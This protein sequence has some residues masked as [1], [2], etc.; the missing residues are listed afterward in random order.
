[1]SG[2]NPFQVLGNWIDQAANAVSDA[3]STVASGVN[4]VFSP[5]ETTIS[6]LGSEFG[7]GISAVMSEVGSIASDVEN[8]GATFGNAIGAA[9]S[10]LANEAAS[11]LTAIG[12]ATADAIVSVGSTI[13]QSMSAW[14][15]TDLGGALSVVE[16]NVATFAKD[17]GHALID[18]AADAV[19]P[20][21]S[22]LIDV[23]WDIAENGQLPSLSGLAGDAADAALGE[24]LP[25]VDEAISSAMPGLLGDVVGGE[26]NTAL[27]SFA[28]DLMQHKSS[29]EILSD[30]K[31]DLKNGANVDLKNLVTIGAEQSIQSL[32]DGSGAID[33][34]DIKTAMSI[35][36]DP[37]GTV[38]DLHITAA[39]LAD[40]T[41]A[42]LLGLGSSELGLPD[43]TQI[44]TAG[45]AL[46][47][48]IA[49]GLAIQSAGIVFTGGVAAEIEDTAASIE[50]LSASALNSLHAIEAGTIKAVDGGLVLNMTQALAVVADKLQLAATPPTVTRTGGVTLRCDQA[51]FDTF[52]S[53]AQLLSLRQAGF[54]FVSVSDAVY[55]QWSLPQALAFAQSGLAL[56]PGNT[57]I[58]NASAV[59]LT[60][61]GDGAATL[62]T[63]D[64]TLMTA[65]GVS[66]LHVTG[67]AAAMLGIPAAAFAALAQAGLSDISY[68]IS[69]TANGL[70]A[71]SATQQQ[72]I[73]LTFSPVSWNVA[74]R[75]AHILALTP[76]AQATL[77]SLGVSGIVCVDTAADIEALTAPQIVTLAANGMTQLRVS[78][79]SSAIS[80]TQE[81]ALQTA[82]LRIITGGILTLRDTAVRLQ[83]LTSLNI[84]AM[85]VLGIRH[86]TATTGPVSLCAAQVLALAVAG[87]SVAVPAGTTL[88]VTDSAANLLALDN[89]QILSLATMGVRTITVDDNPVAFTLGQFFAFSAAGIALS[90]PHGAITAAATSF[91]LAALTVDQV[92]K[93]WHRGIKQ[94]SVAGGAVTLFA[95]M[96]ITLEKAQ[97]T[98]TGAALPSC[99]VQDG[100]L[101]NNLLTLSAAQI[102]GLP[103]IGIT[104]L[105]LAA[106]SILTVAQANAI[107]AAGLT[108]KVS[109]GGGPA[110]GHYTFAIAD[111]AGIIAT[112]S[113][114]QLARFDAMGINGLLP[115]G[116]TVNLSIALVEQIGYLAA[117]FGTRIVVVDSLATINANWNYLNQ[118][119]AA[120]EIAGVVAGRLPAKSSDAPL[121]FTGTLGGPASSATTT[122]PFSAMRLVVGTLPGGQSV[123]APVTV[124]IQILN[125]LGAATDAL[126]RL[127]GATQVGVGTYR[128]SGVNAAAAT[129]ALEAVQ[130]APSALPGSNVDVTMM[131]TASDGRLSTSETITLRAAQPGFL[132][133]TSQVEF[134]VRVA[135]TLWVSDGSTAEQIAGTT[136]AWPYGPGNL[137]PLGA[138]AAYVDGVPG[139]PSE[140]A[141]WITDGE[142]SGSTMLS[143]PDTN[144]AT[145]DP[146]L[147]SPPFVTPNPAGI[148]LINGVNA[149]GQVSIWRTNGTA[150]GTEELTIPGVS[151]ATADDLTQLAG[152]WLFATANSSGGGQVWITSDNFNTY[153][154][155]M[156]LPVPGTGV[157]VALLGQATLLQTS[158]GTY[159][160]N[161]TNH[162]NSLLAAATQPSGL[163]SLGSVALWA[164]NAPG[165][166]GTSTET[167]L[168]Y[169]NGT[170]AGTGQILLPG[171]GDGAAGGPFDPS[172][173]TRF[174]SQALFTGIDASNQRTIWVTNGT[175]K[176]TSE[177]LVNQGGTLLPVLDSA[178]ITAFG[179]KALFVGANASGGVSLWITNGT[180]AGTINLLTETVPPKF[181][182]HVSMHPIA[183]IG[184]QYYFTVVFGAA[185]SG[186]LLAQQLWVTNGTVA[187]TVELT[188]IESL[189]PVSGGVGISLN[190]S[191]IAVG[192]NAVTLAGADSN[193]TVNVPVDVI[194]TLNK[195][196]FIT[197]YANGGDTI[198]ASGAGQT[199]VASSPASG[200]ARDTLIGASLGGD[201][202]L[203]TTAQL[204]GETIGN[205]I[206]SDIIDV[207]DLNPIRFNGVK[208]AA[209]G[210]NTS[211]SLTD[212]THS[213]TIKL[214]GNFGA[215]SF[216]AGADQ[217]GGTVIGLTPFH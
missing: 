164:D 76:S 113:A 171:L 11:G 70:L 79:G 152:S 72:R 150:L 35:V 15:V 205:F 141:V 198:N 92:E 85:P 50:G 30:L 18:L 142:A 19:L 22:V 127:V 117:P 53:A 210:A 138:E 88:G 124:T 185:G 133:T 190:E 62:T 105:E 192:S 27:N 178:G 207:T 156:S 97:I 59:E 60:A 9:V 119:R 212:G 197:A 54:N 45:E 43:V 159:L 137:I 161:P 184:A 94:I 186:P 206:G 74:D 98:L 136:T 6:N 169:T 34:G 111:K 153:Q 21:S 38:A 182:E 158:N 121:L 69:D 170:V 90:D 167:E 187:G 139:N 12:N 91:D 129:A 3:V 135:S 209:N 4:E 122:L 14:V 102:Q 65:A 217:N 216:T 41:P 42:E 165:T 162:S 51:S 32:F 166:A 68:T 132:L 107:I 66:A 157:A 155:V 112:L 101:G 173:I 36:T 67:T 20:G 215:G 120:G 200:V 33:P 58:Y 96:A 100:T 7:S 28:T 134:P 39:A 5:I 29:A 203:G 145:F 78:N 174:G 202:F 147:A 146:S 44:G 37:G 99:A 24:L 130:F 208:V 108:L 211:L 163:V 183:A 46:A 213:T 193:L 55:L 8:V 2:G 199:L 196:S 181:G 71:L 110:T 114:T 48:D 195:M 126:G 82:G 168:W 144:I 13:E 89:Q 106:G 17:Y 148:V 47:V 81:A 118:L 154:Q 86:I 201:S 204:N 109:P 23:A 63:A 125:A 176:G 177:L 191:S 179:T 80:V 160:Y 151:G 75:A 116:G 10:D 87:V 214:V 49:Q 115:F 56:G 128:L 84:A 180:S 1:M 26:A 73:L 57:A 123:T 140:R 189:G 172:S 61:L 188:N 31:T 143:V 25:G 95:A 194:A 16:S 175:A 131:L 64:L 149:E 77:K 104:A 52:S 40:L 103:K 93:L 83:A